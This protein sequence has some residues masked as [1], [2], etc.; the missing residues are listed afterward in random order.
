MADRTS[1]CDKIV[2]HMNEYGSISQL[3]AMQEYG[4]MRLA[5]RI[6][7]LKKKGYVIEDKM[8]HRTNRYGEP[9]HYK[10]YSLGVDA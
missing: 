4:I 1:Q 5:S 3:E 8:V 6:S 10:R 7:D 9:V 2:R